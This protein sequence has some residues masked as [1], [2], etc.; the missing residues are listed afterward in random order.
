MITQ[1][2]DRIRVG[3]R[4]T[5]RART[6]TETDLVSFAMFGL[7]LFPQMVWEMQHALTHSIAAFCFSVVLFLAL[8]ELV[9]RRS[10]AAY[11]LFGVAIGYALIGSLGAIYIGRLDAD[12]KADRLWTV[13]L[14]TEHCEDFWRRN[15]PS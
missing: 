10:L 8:V 3:D 11:V 13:D 5:S 1:P 7:L 12:G 4:H 6:I 2:L 15:A 9:Q 14:D